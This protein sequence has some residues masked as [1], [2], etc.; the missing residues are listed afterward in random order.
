[1]KQEHEQEQETRPSDDYLSQQQL[2]LGMGQYNLA[3]SPPN[4]INGDRY[5]KE[6]NDVD[7]LWMQRTYDNNENSMVMQSQITAVPHN[8]IIPQESQDFSEV[9]SFFDNIDDRQSY[10]VPKEVYEFRYFII[11]T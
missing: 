3:S 5:N 1:M 2:Q 7:T 9:Y 6:C 11:S 8:M 4:N 10:I